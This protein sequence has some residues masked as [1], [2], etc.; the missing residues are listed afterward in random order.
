MFPNPAIKK[1]LAIEV[2]SPFGW[3]RYTGDEGDVLA[4][5]HFGASAPGGTIMKE[6]RLYCRKYCFTCKSI[7]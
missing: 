1:R 6:Y 4:I 5:D 3:D 7:A 2:A